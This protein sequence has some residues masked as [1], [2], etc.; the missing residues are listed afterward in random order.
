[1]TPGCDRRGLAVCHVY[2]SLV[3]IREP[4]DRVVINPDVAFGKPVVRGTRIPVSIV[5]GFLADGMN[6]TEFLEEY[7]Q[8]VEEDV[9]ACL[10]YVALQSSGHFVDVA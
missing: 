8:L 6:V 1:M 3:A 4:I 5:L 10:D 7:P 2:D 9:R